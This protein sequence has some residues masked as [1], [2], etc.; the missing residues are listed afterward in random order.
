L[1]PIRRRVETHYGCIPFPHPG[2][3]IRED[4]LKS[5]QMSDEN[6]VGQVPDL[7]SDPGNSETL[8]SRDHRERTQP[9]TFSRVST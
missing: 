1:S 3:T 6:Q 5:L 7:P 2:V 9:P 8:P 4:F